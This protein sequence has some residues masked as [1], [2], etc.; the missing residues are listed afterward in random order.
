MCPRSYNHAL[1]LR[2]DRIRHDVQLVIPWKTHETRIHFWLVFNWGRGTPD[3]SLKTEEK[4]KWDH[5]LISCI[6]RDF[7]FSFPGSV[8]I[9]FFSASSVVTGTTHACVLRTE[10]GV[11]VL[12]IIVYLVFK[13]CYL[14]IN[15][16]LRDCN[17]F[18]ASSVV[19]GIPQDSA[20]R[21][22]LG[23][24]VFVFIMLTSHWNLLSFE[25]ESIKGIR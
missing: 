7:I 8:Q 21:M 10:V 23:A 2:F 6:L 17:F 1:W 3:L 4:T 20:L 19:M 9:I 24:L 14:L 16:I 12:L 11:F 18:S 13:I 15:S 5:L 22:L 25:W